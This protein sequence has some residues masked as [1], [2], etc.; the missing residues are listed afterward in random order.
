MIVPPHAQMFY[1][2][3]FPAAIQLFLEITTPPPP[4][5]KQKE[6]AVPNEC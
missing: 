5:K 3:F 1:Q 6:W 4:E 2:H